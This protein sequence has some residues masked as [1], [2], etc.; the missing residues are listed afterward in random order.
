MIGKEIYVFYDARPFVPRVQ[1]Y[2]CQVVKETKTGFKVKNLDNPGE[3]EDVVY[4]MNHSARG[5][6][7]LTWE[8]TT[9]DDAEEDYTFLRQAMED[10]H[11]T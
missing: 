6:S 8:F 2:K 9:N 4:Y 11:G 10:N 5:W 3:Y 1:A 7:T